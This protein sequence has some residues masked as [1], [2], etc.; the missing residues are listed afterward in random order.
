MCYFGTPCPLAFIW[1]MDFALNLSNRQ[2]RFYF[3]LDTFLYISF[4]KIIFNCLA[5]DT[6][7]VSQKHQHFLSFSFWCQHYERRFLKLKLIVLPKSREIFHANINLNSF[8]KKKCV[9]RGCIAKYFFLNLKLQRILIKIRIYFQIRKSL[10]LN[11][12]RSLRFY[13]NRNKH[14]V[15]YQYI[16]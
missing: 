15:W 10:K 5:I 12:I 1:G 6:Q 9:G 7:K 4:K 8:W 14:W 2:A 3:A 16:T 11:S 13:F